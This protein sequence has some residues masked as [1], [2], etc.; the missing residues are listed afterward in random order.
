MMQKKATALKATA[1]FVSPTGQI[2]NFF[3]QDIRLILV[4]RNF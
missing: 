4:K 2:S 1:D 3:T